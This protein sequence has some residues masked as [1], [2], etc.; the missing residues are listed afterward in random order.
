MPTNRERL[1]VLNREAWLQAMADR[2]APWFVDLGYPQ[3]KV[4]MALGF[5][6]R[7]RRGRAVPASQI[8]LSCSRSASLPGSSSIGMA[9]PGC[10][11]SS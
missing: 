5:T 8:S 1:D 7:G 11:G 3:P 4:R 10:A 6:S 9:K 2:M